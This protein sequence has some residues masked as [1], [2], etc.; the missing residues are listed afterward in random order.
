[1]DFIF[2][3]KFLND[4]QGNADMEV[5]ID[6]PQGILACICWADQN[7][8][9]LEDYLP[10]KHLPLIDGKGTYK[11][12]NGLFIP[13][14]ASKIICRVYN[15][16]MH[17]IVIPELVKDIPDNKKFIPGKIIKR[18]VACSDMHCGGNYF[19]NT[20]NRILGLNSIR[21]LKPDFV[22]FSG[23]IAD[24]SNPE[25]YDMA[26]TMFDMLESI[27]AFIS[28]GN[29]DLAP[30]K[31]GCYP[32]Y[33]EIAEFF[34]WHRQ[35][36]IKLGAEVGEI[37]LPKYYYD[38]KYGDVAVIVLDSCNAENKFFLGEEQLKWFEEKLTE[39][40]GAR[41]R[42][43]VNHF[44]IAGT[45]GFDCCGCIP[46][47]GLNKPFAENDEVL[48][49]LEK[50]ENVIYIS[51]HTHKNSDNDIRCVYFD[52]EHKNLHIDAGCII[53]N[54]V[55]MEIKR[56]YY[57]QNRSTAQIIDIYDDYII[58]RSKDFVSGK[59]IS[60]SVHMCRM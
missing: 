48:E 24:N 2:D 30:Y 11:N 28:T 3:V 25:E 20:N 13:E 26:R 60:R 37:Q 7:G 49:L 10:I 44:P 45:V 57:L 38:A 52:K 32:H 29:H 47:K 58:T 27:P 46:L 55:N 31:P 19:N 56:E 18:I 53:W 22:T 14:E 16:Y 50:H 8:K 54:S 51:G 23:D 36:N 39:S 43:V 40:D 35:R 15:D 42:V 9:P 33:E 6:I 34:N 17:E 59:Y 21:E 5:V 41:Y 12:E 4:L 1:M